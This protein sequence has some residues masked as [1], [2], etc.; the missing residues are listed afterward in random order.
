MCH[1]IVEKILH[2]KQIKFEAVYVD[3]LFLTPMSFLVTYSWDKPSLVQ[4]TWFL[5]M[6]RAWRID[7]EIETKSLNS[8]PIPSNSSRMSED[9]LRMSED[10]S[11]SSVNVRPHEEKWQE[12][13]RKKIKP[14]C[15]KTIIMITY[16]FC[17]HLPPLIISE[18]VPLSDGLL[19]IL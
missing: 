4:T 8:E 13:R 1:W 3:F 15:L 16:S 19:W 10:F 7:T 18:W 11:A 14:V 12:L 9:M 2:V 6:S 17:E 5:W